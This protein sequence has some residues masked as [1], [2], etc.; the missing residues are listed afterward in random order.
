MP[1][2]GNGWYSIY[3]MINVSQYERKCVLNYNMQWK[4]T[5]TNS[6]ALVC[7]QLVN[8]VDVL[9]ESVVFIC[10]VAHVTS[11]RSSSHQLDESCSREGDG[12]N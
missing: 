12:V 2:S 10:E 11:C 8:V 7:N 9:G 6:Q 1:L 3:G 4:Q 5:H